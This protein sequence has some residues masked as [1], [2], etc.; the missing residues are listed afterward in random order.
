[1]TNSF[2]AKKAER[3]REAAD[4]YYSFI[5][6]FPESKHINAAQRMFKEINKITNE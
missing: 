1:M 3:A 2:E 4:E 5:N 6:Q